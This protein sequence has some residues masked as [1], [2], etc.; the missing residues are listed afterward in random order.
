MEFYVKRDYDKYDTS[1]QE[2]LSLE[3]RVC[4]QLFDNVENHIVGVE[5]LEQGALRKLREKLLGDHKGSMPEYRI[6]LAEAMKYLI[7]RYEHTRIVKI[8]EAPS[9]DKVLTCSCRGFRQMG[10]ACRHMYALLRRYPSIRDAKIRWHMG[11]ANNYG[12]DVDLTKHYINLRDKLSLPG[13]LV[14]PEEIWTITRELYPV[15]YGDREI[16][17]FTCSMGRLKLRGRD[18][19]WHQ[20]ATK[21]PLELRQYLPCLGMEP[22]PHRDTNDG[23]SVNIDNFEVDSEFAQGGIQLSCNVPFG[24]NQALSQLSQYTVPSQLMPDET[25]PLCPPQGLNSYHDFMHIYQDL[26]KMA[27]GNGDEGR[28]ALGRGLNELRSQQ[29]NI[30]G[31]SVSESGMATFPKL[32]RKRKATRLCKVTSPQK[33]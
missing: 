13:I 32:S 23:G 9:G 2:D 29:F 27:D 8:I 28:Q 21:L 11:Y 16:T 26:C 1:P 10:Y 5:T 25:M 17:F 3:Y 15:G 14:T 22:L 31:V 33:R 30:S 6:L 4:Q 12:H 24:A 18:N 7:P 19:Y 20:H